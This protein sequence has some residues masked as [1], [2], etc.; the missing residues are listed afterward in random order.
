M[1][2]SC[3]AS[4]APGLT[5]SW[6]HKGMNITQLGSTR[7]GKYRIIG[8]TADRTATSTLTLNQLRINDSGVIACIAM[9]TV[10]MEDSQDA[11]PVVFTNFTATSLSVLGKYT[12][13]EVGV[14]HDHKWSQ[15]HVT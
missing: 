15:Y 8:T 1:T 2:L 13:A 6:T 5:L 7:S 11:I 10:F 3:A 4:G 14:M 12:S 9:V